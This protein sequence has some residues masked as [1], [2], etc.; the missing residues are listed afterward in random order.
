M[1]K[2]EAKR[3]GSRFTPFITYF[4]AEWI[5]K[6]GP[7]LF[8]VFLKSYR[9]NNLVESYNSNIRSK[10]PPSGCFFKFVEFLQK[11]ELIK[12]KDY[13][14]IK[15]GG[16]QVYAPQRKKYEERDEFITKNQKKFDSDQ[17]FS[18]ADFF[19]TIG[20][21]NESDDDEESE[22]SSLSDG[23][24]DDDTVFCVVCKLK[25][26]TTLLEPCNELKFCQSCVDKIM[27]PQNSKDRNIKPIC[28][29]CGVVVTGTKIV[30]L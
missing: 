15:G 3:F 27:V 30:F 5:K 16:T 25:A 2:T 19:E 4:E 6:V 22:D 10:I 13:E 20:E 29:A 7:N 12:S 8:C 18:V 11:E 1:F 17:R 28:P 21:L 24:H 14:I 26:R 9:T 23:D